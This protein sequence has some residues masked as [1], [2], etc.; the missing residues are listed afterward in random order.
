MASGVGWGGERLPC[1]G[2]AYFSRFPR[3]ESLHLA[4]PP[5]KDTA[6]F[7]TISFLVGSLAS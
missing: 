1:H 5:A 4:T 6:L 7:G 3:A 2:A